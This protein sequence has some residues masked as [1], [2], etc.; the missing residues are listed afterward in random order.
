MVK[1]TGKSRRKTRDIFKKR[2]KE[3]G[4]I[5]LTKYFQDFKVGDKVILKAEPAYQRGIYFQRY[6]GVNG[7]VKGKRGSCCIV[8]INNLGKLK[9]LII[10]PVHLKRCTK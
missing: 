10:H 8:E 9:S 4:K 3:K 2:V 1:R 7:I 5:S 6:H